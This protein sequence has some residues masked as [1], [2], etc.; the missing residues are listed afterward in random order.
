MSADPDAG[1]ILSEAAIA[2]SGAQRL[3]DDPALQAAFRRLEAAY[4]NQ[5]RTS[6]PSDKDARKSAFYML[7]ALDAL[8]GDIDAVMAGGAVA[9]RNLRAVRTN[10]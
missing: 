6:A 3:R 4:I 7:R 8:K 9:A 1:R 10:R 5:F 2:A